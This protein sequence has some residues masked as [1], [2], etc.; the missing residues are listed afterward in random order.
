MRNLAI[1]VAVVVAAFAGQMLN[2]IV[3]GL[4]SD[5]EYAMSAISVWLTGVTATEVAFSPLT[6]AR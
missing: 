6:G 1:P 3:A 4:M 2:V 5:D